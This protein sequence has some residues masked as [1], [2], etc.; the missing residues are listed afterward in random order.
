LAVILIALFSS[1]IFFKKGMQS[2]SPDVIVDL[3]ERD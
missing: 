3:P 2:P 1:L